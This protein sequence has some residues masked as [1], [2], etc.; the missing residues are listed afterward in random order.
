MNK[1]NF[2]LKVI[3]IFLI[4]NSFIKLKSMESVGSFLKNLFSTNNILSGA[5]VV[6]GVGISGLG[7]L[8]IKND[9]KTNISQEQEE[10]VITSLLEAQKKGYI[11]DGA[12]QE[13]KDESF[14]KLKR[15]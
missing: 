6:T 12:L 11:P 1:N 10:A 7:L 5:L 2:K 9:I 14:G 4:F 8:L 3:L 15:R 13:L